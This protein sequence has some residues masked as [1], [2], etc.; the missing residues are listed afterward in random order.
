MKLDIDYLECILTTVETND[1]SRVNMKM[2]LDALKTM[3]GH[4]MDKFYNHMMRISEAGFLKCDN[5]EFGFIRTMSGISP[6]DYDY[7]LAWEG[8]QYLE[9]IRDDSIGQKAKDL[10]VNMSIEQFK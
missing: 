8:Y 10:L 9:A 5:S 3:P 7:E 6:V 2:I 4:S 1:N